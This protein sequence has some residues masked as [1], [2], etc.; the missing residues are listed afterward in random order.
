MTNL[1]IKTAPWLR[2]L[3]ENDAS[4]INCMSQLQTNLLASFSDGKTPEY[5][6]SY[7]LGEQE[8]ISRTV[9]WFNDLLI[10]FPGEPRNMYSQV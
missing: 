5:E 1:N 8:T 9:F 2:E 6:A 7:S 3:W 4:I 10:K